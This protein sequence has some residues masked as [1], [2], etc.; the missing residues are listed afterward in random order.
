MMLLD[1]HLAGLAANPSTIHHGALPPRPSIQYKS[2]LKG[3]ALDLE[4]TSDVSRQI[5]V[6]LL[7]SL[8]RR[9]SSTRVDPNW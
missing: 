9:D 5:A 7:R 6:R 3:P 2:C 8:L 1:R 4:R